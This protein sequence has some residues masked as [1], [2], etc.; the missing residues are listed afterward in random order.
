MT[1]RILTAFIP[2]SASI[3]SEYV[4]VSPT[5][6][7][8]CEHSFY[9]VVVTCVYQD[10]VTDTELANTSLPYTSAAARLWEH[11]NTY[12]LYYKESKI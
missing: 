1:L 3:I 2:S 4:Y 12:N 10:P 9:G 7:Q 5:E 6:D 8:G 11:I